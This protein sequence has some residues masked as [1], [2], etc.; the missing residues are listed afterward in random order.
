M[1][2]IIL[3][4]VFFGAVVV[5]KAFINILRFEF[6]RGNMAEFNKVFREGLDRKSVV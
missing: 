6:L 2:T 1:L 4:L 3:F 5:Q